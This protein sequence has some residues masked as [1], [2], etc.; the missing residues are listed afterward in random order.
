MTTDDIVVRLIDLP[1]EVK[2][3]TLKS[4]DGIYNMYINARLSRVM[5]HKTHEHEMEH[6]I[7]EDFYAEI[8][9]GVLETLA[10][11]FQ[12]LKTGEY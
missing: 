11:G 10:K 12:R 4:P 6:I 7:R 8:P 9:V 2:G 1:E 5:Q 3:F